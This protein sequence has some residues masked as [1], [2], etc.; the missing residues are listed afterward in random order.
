MYVRIYN[1]YYRLR[2]TNN[3]GKAELKPRSWSF[4]NCPTDI[5]VVYKDT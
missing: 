1:V 3:G 2:Y 5:G 4:S